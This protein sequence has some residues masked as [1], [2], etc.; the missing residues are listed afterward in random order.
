MNIPN[1]EKNNEYNI[2]VL[3][4]EKTFKIYAGAGNQKIRWLSDSAIYKYETIFNKKCNLAYGV[5]LE[6]GQTCDLDKQINQVLKFNENIWILLYE[7]YEAF[8]NTGQSDE[9]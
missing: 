6:N 4:K 7:E 1:Y 3:I 2:N 8:K 5:K 9:E